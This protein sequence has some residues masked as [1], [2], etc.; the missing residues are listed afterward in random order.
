MIESDGRNAHGTE[1]VISAP[2]ISIIVAVYNGAS[3]IQECINSVKRQRDSSY[4][5][6]VMDG[7]SSD[8]TPDLLK[9]NAAFLA[10]WESQADRGIAHAWNKGLAV[11]KG[12]WILFIGADD[13]LADDTV[14]A[15]ARPALLEG[16]CD[17]VYGRLLFVGGDLHNSSIGEPFD[18][19]KFRRRMTI[20]HPSTFHHRSLFDA[21]G[22]YDETYRIALDYELLL[23]RESLSTR[24]VD[25]LITKMSATGVSSRSLTKSLIEAKRA[26]HRH[27]PNR[28]L[29][30]ELFHWAYRIRA[31][32]MMFWKGV[33]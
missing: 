22:Q 15:K 25:T 8:G 9:Q 2:L 4:E 12:E 7:G 31:A 23:R 32:I 30:T 3:T 27:F 21:V 18:R 33:A 24:Y 10:H 16:V 29:R 5:L 28:W 17:L 13:Q 20:P 1:H 19:K 14:L 11:A 6:I 26:Q